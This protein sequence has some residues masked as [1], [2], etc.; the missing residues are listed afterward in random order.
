MYGN[1]EDDRLY[2]GEHDDILKG[3][4]GHDRLRGGSGHDH[5]YG[6]TGNDKLIGGSDADRFRLSKGND[7]I[8]D[9]S[10]S[11][12]D[13]IV[14]GENINLAIAKSGKNLLLSDGNNG[15]NT[16]LVNTS[17]NRF[18]SYQSDLFS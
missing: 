8:K 16:T 17:L 13:Q 12:G 7:R 3:G 2:G 5:L 9:F 4:T 1:R 14:I 10:F 15:I 11:E 18:L 6:G